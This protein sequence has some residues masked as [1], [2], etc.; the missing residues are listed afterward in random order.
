MWIIRSATDA[1]ILFL[2]ATLYAC[3][4]IEIEG[5]NG[6]AA[7]LPTAKNFLGHLT[8]YHVYMVA[9]AAIIVSG[10]AYYRSSKPCKDA[11]K[12][13]FTKLRAGVAN[14]VFMLTLFFLLQ[15]FL[16]FVLNPSF[17][18]KK[19]TSSY[20]PWHK[21]WFAGIPWFVYVGGA[22]LLLA[23]VISPDRKE[24]A[25]CGTTS[26]LLLGGI[27][28]AAPLYHKFYNKVH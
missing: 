28:A 20:I 14:I 24:L 15:D 13:T 12:S 2:F 3:I 23:F 19:Y 18:I 22:M 8:L 11:T 27:I 16:W 6:W 26:G 10:F 17:T 21:P 5:P 4:E 7:N 25:V 1:F 9:L